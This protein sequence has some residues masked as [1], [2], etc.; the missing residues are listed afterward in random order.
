MEVHLAT[1]LP[2]ELARK[3]GHG[4][5]HD[6][7]NRVHA[8]HPFQSLHMDPIERSAAVPLRSQF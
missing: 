8:T 2:L 7:G 1:W 3:D 6:G 4:E 5:L